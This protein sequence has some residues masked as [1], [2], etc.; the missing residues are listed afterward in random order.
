M[1]GEIM[2][3][4][5]HL[6]NFRR[7]LEMPLINYKINLDLNWYKQCAVVAT[8]VADQGATYSITDTKLYVTVNEKIMQ[9]CLNN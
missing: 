4:L 8:D 9:N 5:K 7:T 2:L 6:N 1:C 3:P